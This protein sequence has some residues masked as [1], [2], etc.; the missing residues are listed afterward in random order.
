MPAKGQRIPLSK[1]F[2]GKYQVCDETGCWIWTAAT[3]EGRYGVLW[4]ADGKSKYAHRVSYEFHIGQIPS[5]MVVCHRCDNGLCVNPEHLFAG[6]TKDNHDDMHSKGRGQ[7]FGGEKNPSS[8]LNSKQVEEIRKLRGSK[9]S[10]EEIGKKFS[11]SRGTIKSIWSGRTWA[12]GTN[13][14]FGMVSDMNAANAAL[15]FGA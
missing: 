9:L 11:V 10:Q 1:R 7:K 12:A 3:A 14:K 4:F 2:E 15:S 5:G 13:A 8:K 6:T